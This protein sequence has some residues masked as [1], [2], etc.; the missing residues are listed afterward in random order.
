MS[1]RTK[2]FIPAIAVFFFLLAFTSVKVYKSM[3][4]MRSTA[5]NIFAKNE[6]PGLRWVDPIDSNQ[7]AFPISVDGELYFL[8]ERV[9][10]EDP[11]VK[12]RLD[13]ELQLNTYCH[14]NTISSMRLANRY[15][16]QIEKVLTE[17]GV[18]T[19]FKYLA[20]VESGF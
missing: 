19:D 15:F 6:C 8:G 11:D 14:S 18:P 5:V 4:E 20:L 16:G 12:E 2:Y 7:M 1:R 3:K 10:L 9:P 17:N 13:R